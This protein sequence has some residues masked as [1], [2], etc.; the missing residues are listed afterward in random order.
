MPSLH[1]KWGSA[2]WSDNLPIKDL[3]LLQVIGRSAG[4]ARC[5]NDEELSEK[6]SW[7]RLARNVSVTITVRSA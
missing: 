4:V 6:F 5:T 3:I 2:M 1:H 7:M